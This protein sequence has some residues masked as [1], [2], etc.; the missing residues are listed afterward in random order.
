MGYHRMIQILKVV[1]EAVL[2]VVAVGGVAA[3]LE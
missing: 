1:E 2:Q 3:G